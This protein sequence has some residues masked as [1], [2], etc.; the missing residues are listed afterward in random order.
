[1][2]RTSTEFQS[3]LT[4]LARNLTNDELESMKFWCRNQK[5]A[6][7]AVMEEINEPEKLW[8]V[9]QKRGKLN[10]HDTEFLKQLLRQSIQRVDLIGVINSYESNLGLSTVDGETDLS[11]VSSPG[12]DA[13]KSYLQPLILTRDRDTGGGYAE[14]RLLSF[15]SNLSLWSIER[16]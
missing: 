5:I 13:P 1:M 12:V 10:H 2:N 9:L 8:D 16:V 11:T 4:S 14:G 15:L 7:R 6:G 3:M